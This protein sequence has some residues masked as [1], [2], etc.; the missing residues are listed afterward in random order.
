MEAATGVFTGS[1][2][3]D[4]L[5]LSAGHHGEG[6]SYSDGSTLLQKTHHHYKMPR[7][8]SQVSQY[9]LAWRRHHLGQ[10]GGRGV[11]VIRN[12]YKAILS[13]WNFSKTKSH[14]NSVATES[15][16]SEEFQKFVRVGAERW[17][18]VMQDWLQFSTDCYVIMY[19]VSLLTSSNLQSD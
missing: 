12:P 7:Y 17:R 19:E 14:T 11:L 16:Q 13:Y 6:R 18:E 15:L 4:S 5:L 2:Y 1:M 8:V 10:F 3:N 9:S